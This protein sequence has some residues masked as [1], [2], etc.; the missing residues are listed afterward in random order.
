MCQS[1]VVGTSWDDCVNGVEDRPA[2]K[3][4]FKQVWNCLVA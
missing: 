3:S 4:C 1:L 2:P